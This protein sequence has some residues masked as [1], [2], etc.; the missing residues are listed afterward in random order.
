MGWSKLTIF[1]SFKKSATAALVAVATL[2]P[3]QASERLNLALESVTK[4]EEDKEET[5]ELVEEPP[6]VEKP[7][8]EIA[9][10]PTY[11]GRGFS[12]NESVVLR[13]FQERGITDRA[14]LAVL[15]GNIRQ[16][17]MFISNIC[18]GGARVNYNS[19]RWGGYGLIQWTT[20]DRYYGLGRFAKQTGGNPSSIH[21]QLGY[22]VTER[23]WKS[24]EWKMRTPGL[25]ISS[26]MQAAY[27]WLGWGIH[28][29]RTSYAY[30]YYDRLY[31]D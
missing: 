5:T 26:Y 15:L 10:S 7:E 21:T 29:A 11:K 22:L 16:E 17:S 4:A 31:L 30:N 20:S 13:Y 25:G 9:I 27:R 19:C 28:G 2:L 23:Q 18:E 14:A 24:I 6:K 8:P 12:Y 1:M 3:L